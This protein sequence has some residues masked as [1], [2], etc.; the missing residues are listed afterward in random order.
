VLKAINEA[1]RRVHA[2]KGDAGTLGLD[3]LAAQAHAFE[4]ELLRIREP[5]AAEHG[6]RPAVAAH[7]AGRPAA[8][9]WPRSRA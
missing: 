2:I 8:T 1:C 4:S 9:R 7:A 3:T 5:G 6:R